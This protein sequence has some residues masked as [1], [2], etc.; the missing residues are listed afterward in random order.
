MHSTGSVHSTGRPAPT[1]ACQQTTMRDGPAGQI[2]VSIAAG[3]PVSDA[4]CSDMPLAP[5]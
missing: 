5:Q 3:I 2:M 4:G 1:A